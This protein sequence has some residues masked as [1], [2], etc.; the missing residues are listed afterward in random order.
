MLD[1]ANSRYSALSSNVFWL[2]ALPAD[3]IKNRIMAD[4]LTVPKYKGVVHAA[5]VIWAEGGPKMFYKGFI[6][7][8][9]RAVRLDITLT[10]TDSFMIIVAC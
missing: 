8:L 1:D 3:S 4:S 5:K 7:A 6:P 9:L 10:K 2:T